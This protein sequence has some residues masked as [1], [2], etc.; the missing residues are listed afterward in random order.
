MFK[1]TLG[2]FIVSL[3]A[4]CGDAGKDKA[5]FAPKVFDQGSDIKAAGVPPTETPDTPASTTYPVLRAPK[6]ATCTMPTQ[7]AQQQPL[8]VDQDF[9]KLEFICPSSAA[10]INDA[11]A[12]SLKIFQANAQGGYSLV[13][14]VRDE[15]K[16]VAM[17]EEILT[18][19]GVTIELGLSDGSY[20]F[21]LC[22]AAKHAEC[23]MPGEAA[24]QLPSSTSSIPD[25]SSLPPPP[26][27]A[28]SLSEPSGIVGMG[29]LEVKGGHVSSQRGA[30]GVLAL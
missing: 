12:V 15:A 19:S 3:A 22:D 8:G 1:V 29:Q 26:S 7:E 6:F 16:A 9:V 4:A 25:V 18:F 21:L 17:R 28:P 27:G 24:P 5:Q 14:E 11:K 10:N 2:L 20:S 30:I 13:A 23:S